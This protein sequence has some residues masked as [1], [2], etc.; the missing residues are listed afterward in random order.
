MKNWSPEAKKVHVPTLSW[1]LENPGSCDV[2]GL[3]MRSEIQFTGQSLV[4][5]GSARAEEGP[6]VLAISVGYASLSMQTWS[7]S[8]GCAGPGVGLA[9]R[10]L[11][12]WS[13]GLA[14]RLVAVL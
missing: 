11:F 9:L 4:G 13:S 5:P 1:Q 2:M 12:S 10:R 3:L 6:L 7:R 8:H 14:I